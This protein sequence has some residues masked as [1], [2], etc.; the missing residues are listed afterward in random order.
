MSKEIQVLFI[1]DEE[2]IID[3]VQRLFAREP[4]A[5]F[6]TTSP[7]KAREALA[8]EKIKVVVSDYR[9]P[10]ISGVKFLREV[11]EKYPDMVKILFTGYTDFSAA[12]EA[13]NVGEVYRFISKP[14][15]TAELLSTIRQ[16]IEH[17]DLVR[18]AKTKTEELEINN[19]KLKNMYRNINGVEFKRLRNGIEL[20]KH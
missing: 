6:A 12:E 10:E 15:K 4:Y 17:Y 19:K 18:E 11:K 7:D 16:C 13:I 2:S 20:K 9:M 1:D 5:I 3:G 8:K 14:W